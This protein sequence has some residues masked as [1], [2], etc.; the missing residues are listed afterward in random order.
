M[1]K[2]QQQIFCEAAEIIQG[3]SD[4]SEKGALD[5]ALTTGSK[6]GSHLMGKEADKEGSTG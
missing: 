6:A 5:Q 4:T 3:S 1:K 2:H